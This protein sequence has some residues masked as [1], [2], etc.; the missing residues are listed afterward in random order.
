M[1]LYRPLSEISLGDTAEFGGKAAHLGEAMRL[2]CSVLSGVALS[3]ELYRRFMRQGG[4]QGEVRSILGSM[5]PQAMGQFQAAAWAI[6][7]AFEVR[8]MP[9]EIVAVIHEAWHAVGADRVA[10]R[11]SAT[12]EDSPNQSFVGQHAYT[13]DVDSPEAL[14]QAVL[15]CWI[16]LFSSQAL[17]YANTF[18]VDLLS[19][20]MA[21]LIQPMVD[22]DESGALYTADPVTGDP[23]VFLLAVREGPRAGIHEL[24]PFVRSAAEEDYW[25]QLRGMGLLLDERKLAY[26]SMDWVLDNGQVFLLRDRPVTGAPAYLPRDAIECELHAAPIEWIHPAGMSPREA[27]PFSWYHVSRGPSLNT[28]PAAQDDTTL[29]ETQARL[30]CYPCGYLYASEAAPGAPMASPALPLQRLLLDARLLWH[31]RT[32]DRSYLALYDQDLPRLEKINNQDLGSLSSTRLAA[33]LEEVIDLHDALWAESGLLNRTSEALIDLLQRLNRAWLHQDSAEMD[34]LLATE[35]DAWSRVQVGLDE[36]ALADYPSEREREAAQ[37]AF[38][39]RHR[40]HF[41]PGDPLAP[42]RDLAEME[43]DRGLLEEAWAARGPEWRPMAQVLAERAEA[44]ETALEELLSQ[45]D[46]LRGAIYRRVVRV[47]RHYHTLARDS[48][49]PVILCR[50]LEADL[51]R[52]AGRRMLEVG[53]VD[54]DADARLFEAQ[55]ILTW[56]QGQNSNEEMMRV[57]QRRR[58][59]FRRWARYTPPERIEAEPEEQPM[60]ERPDDQVFEGHPVCAGVATGRARVIEALSEASQTLPGEILV[61]REPWFELSPLFSI[62]AAVVSEEGELLDHAGVLTREYGV[63]AVFGV[64][65]ATSRIETGDTLVVDAKRGIVIRRLPEP[66]WDMWI[67]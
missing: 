21:V 64:A 37:S 11:S 46:P 49:H 3:V 15:D 61:C 8:R 60:P 42:W 47:A 27:K 23:D 17:S 22:S 2:G 53:V 19:S 18:R 59:T 7:S 34:L 31:A 36:L 20:A 56:L 51:V 26:R 13:M 38:F 41:V 10:V 65:E 57:A 58:M 32:L 54:A 40:H 28:A 14:V 45:L 4:L 63:P 43:A 35:E 25:S 5:Q 52:D 55:Q 1:A 39:Q 48:R 30:Q 66:E 62:V 12:N 67:I 44:R 50:L 33:M 29:A 16:S 9:D 24:D 6:H